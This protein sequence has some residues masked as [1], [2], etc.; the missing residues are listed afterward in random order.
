MSDTTNN[1]DIEKEALEFYN[2]HYPHSSHKELDKQIK[3]W[4]NKVSTS[5]A[6]VEF[7]TERVGDVRNKR[8]LDVGFGSGGVATAFNLAGAVV[9]GVDVEPDLKPIADK[10][11]VANKASADLRIYNGTELPFEDNFFDYIVC[12]AVLEHVSFPVQVLKE[13]FRVLKSGGRM[14]LALP[15]RYAPKET[16]TLAYFVSYMPR[17]MASWYLK[18]LKRSPL[19]HDNLHFYSYFAVMRMLK[20]TGYKYELLYKDM[21]EM[22]GIKKIVASFLKKFNIHYTILLRQLMFILEKK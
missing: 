3:D 9:Y 21:D 20:K 1:M 12:S 8:V 17:P 16:H 6:F 11:L 14:W 4:Q 2:K 15:N 13:M 22:T 10:N 5:R 7:Y 19:E 18:L